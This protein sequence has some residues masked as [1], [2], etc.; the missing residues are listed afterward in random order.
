M[1]ITLAS[2]SKFKNNILNTV[3][4]KHDMVEPNFLENSKEKDVYKYV[5]EL[6]LGKAQSVRK[7]IKEGIIIGIDTVVLINGRIVE[8][9]ESLAEARQNLVDS[10]NNTVS[11]V[12]GVTLINTESNQ[13]LSDYQETKV[14]FNEIKDED[15]K[16]Y[17]E[18]EPDALYASGF[19]V[20][21]IASNFI[22][23]IHGSYYNILGVPVEKI[24][25]LLNNMGIY[26]K[27][28]D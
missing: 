19:I 13:V 25:Q 9:P 6:S 5:C 16:F 22:K 4:I 24:Y 23:E 7:T 26:L 1:K 17:L 21:T 11:V 2:T 8:K 10:S 28:I 27:D 20:E 14:V 18:N 3:K 15:I 12:S